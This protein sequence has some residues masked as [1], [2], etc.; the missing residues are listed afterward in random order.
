MP[1]PQ[2]RKLFQQRVSYFSRRL[3][4]C[5]DTEAEQ[6]LVRIA[7]V[8]VLFTYLALTGT[9]S[10]QESNS[11]TYLWLTWS[12][13]GTSLG[14]LVWIYLNPRKSVLRRVVGIALDN[15][16][17]S[18]MMFYGEA[19]ATPVF[20]VYL[21]VT[22][23]NGFRYGNPYLFTSMALSMCFF[24]IVYS[25]STYWRDSYY[26]SWG[27]LVSLF[28]L[29]LY[30]SKLVRR[31]R[32]A[33]DRAESANHAKTSFLANMSHEIRT[34]LNGVIGMTDLLVGT[35]L[36][37]EQKDFVQTIQASANALLSLVEDILDISKIEV[38]KISI[39]QQECDLPM[40]INSTAKM[41][42]PQATEKGLYLR[43]EISND[44]PI[45][46]ISDPQHLRQV[47]IN[48]IGNAIK[49][50]EI[51]G[52]EV[53][54]TRLDQK[55]DKTIAVR[56]E[57]IDTGIGIPTSVQEKIFDTFTQADESVTRKYGGTGL[58]TAISKQLIELM[59]GKI[60]LQSSADQ[61]SRFW[62]VLDFNLPTSESVTPGSTGLSSKKVLVL[63][64]QDD[65]NG[66]Y[67]T[68]T[69]W[70]RE[71]QAVHSEQ[72]AL[73]TLKAGVIDKD[74][75]DL[76]L[77]HAPH[78]GKVR[79]AESVKRDQ[80]LKELKLVLVVAN[81]D[82]QQTELFKN[83]GY[84][85][86]LSEPV[87]VALLFNTL[88]NAVVEDIPG[89][90][91]ISRLSDYYTAKAKV[92]GLNVLVAED[93]PINQ[94][95]IHKIL[96]RAGHRVDL[97]QNG[98]IALE[99]L[100]E[101]S[102]DLAI[103]DM[104]MPIMG[105]IDAIKMFR[106]GHPE[107]QMP[108]IVLTANATTEALKEC[109]EVRVDAFV[110]KP[111]QAKKLVDTID[112]VVSRSRGEQVTV[113]L[114]VAKKDSVPTADLTKLAELASL[115]HEPKF[116]EE[117]VHS[118]LRDGAQL[119]EEIRDAHHHGEILRVKDVSHALKGSA[120]SLGA[121]RLYETAEKLNDMSMSQFHD[122]GAELIGQAEDDFSMVSAELKTYLE[123]Q[124]AESSM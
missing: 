55:T 29:P 49:F 94:K 70:V 15:A 44:V 89:L 88:H 74:P 92:V 113:D 117:L 105:G 30:A 19:L 118:F 39:E 60:G 87:D 51:G 47:L 109:E 98:Q 56:F 115:S 59:G 66:L 38:G 77:V 111:Y 4:A 63:Q 80:H 22:L 32:E 21:W 37:R 85:D 72:Q 110:T 46:V 58:G 101:R 34:P 23:G 40:L 78:V 90:S 62:F 83:T 95:V 8:S 31:L 53:R 54:A 67:R 20:A 104:Q 123:Q 61:G 27:I 1:Y 112:S 93:N 64:S 6:A 16:Y 107:S 120:A 45:I 2:I 106:F 14:I 3:D 57:V 79:F 33:I 5:P 48:L 116:L 24:S 35:R 12:S 26:F 28:I 124:H 71:T 91:D 18:V 119:L 108:F 43:V 75:F 25:L 82:T 9:F 50:T 100:E 10:K 114:P 103:V 13:V 36:N 99:K 97:V 11:V 86:V 73:R 96:E 69:P 17:V 42:K 7:V 65:R 122:Q 68:V 121:T 41:L 84:S 76:V 81:P 102:Y 52:I